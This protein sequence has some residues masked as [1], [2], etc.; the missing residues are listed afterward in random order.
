MA[1]TA[2][3]LGRFLAQIVVPSSGSSAMSTA[4]PFPL[5]TSSPIY[6][7]FDCETIEFLAHGVDCGL[8]GGFFVAAPAQSGGR[9]RGTLGDAH[10][11]HGEYP[12]ETGDNVLGHIHREKSSFTHAS[13]R[14]A[15]LVS[16]LH[17]K[18]KTGC[19]NF[20]KSQQYQSIKEER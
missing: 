1:M 18:G 3:A 6:R 8:V 19:V 5:P 14:G 16:K 4:G 10:N 13:A 12:V 17:D 11:F 2:S 15:L 9:D 7:A 20:S